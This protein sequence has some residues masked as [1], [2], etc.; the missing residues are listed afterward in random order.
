MRV[1]LELDEN[2]VAKARA[3]T[4]IEAIT[5]L[6]HE[7][8]EALVQRESNRRAS[9]RLCEERSGQTTRRP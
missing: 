9:W 3:L 4:G 7:A 5:P 8:M 6:A 1:T 2:L